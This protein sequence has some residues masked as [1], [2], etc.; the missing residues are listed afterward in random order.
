[1][2]QHS[3]LK[4]TAVGVRHRNV[5]KRHERIQVL[6]SEEKWGNRASVYKLPKMK[7]IKIKMKKTKAKQE[8]E[9]PAE[10]AP[11]PQ[12]G[13]EASL[14]KPPPTKSPAPTKSTAPKPQAK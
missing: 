7:L 6:Q 5:L 11:K 12:A 3:S 8:G 13:Q 1:M 10:G 14:V 9:S 4:G 2:T